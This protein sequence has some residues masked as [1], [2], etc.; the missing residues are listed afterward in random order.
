MSASSS[1]TT[2]RGTREGAAGAGLPG[3]G[4]A[5]AAVAFEGFAFVDGT[6]RTEGAELSWSVTLRAYF[7]R[8][9]LASTSNVCDVVLTHPDRGH[10]VRPDRRSRRS[11]CRERDSNPHA[12]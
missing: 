5:T 3:S 11:W 9:N 8:T 2:T 1:A 6:G 10:D 4:A 7:P 12:L